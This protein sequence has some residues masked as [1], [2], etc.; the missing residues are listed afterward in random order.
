MT[1]NEGA[2][3]A[4]RRRFGVAA[5]GVAWSRE[6][7][8][9]SSAHPASSAPPD[10]PVGSVSGRARSALCRLIPVRARVCKP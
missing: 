6:H 5:P 2:I 7:P 8:P 4:A 10:K 3:S 9:A 1:P